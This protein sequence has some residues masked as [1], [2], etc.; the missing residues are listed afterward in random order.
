MTW[1]CIVESV[2]V[3]S[4]II[5]TLIAGFGAWVA[6]QTL[7]RTPVQEP[8]P[9]GAE[10][11]EAE[12]TALSEVKVFETSKQTTWLKITE[13]GLECHLQ[14]RREGKRSGHQ[15]TLTKEQ[16][17]AILSTHNYRVYPGYRLRSGVFSIG[18]RRNWLY[19]KRLYPDAELLEV[20]LKGLLKRAGT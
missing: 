11:K 6:Y 4:Q 17:N 20:E 3:A 1:Q 13:K 10:V 14:D 12:I 7:L 9:E 8:E 15:W 2:Q 5:T 18:P 16:A 19:S